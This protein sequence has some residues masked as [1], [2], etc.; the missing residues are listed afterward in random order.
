MEVLL[1]SARDS[2]TYSQIPRYPAIERDISL[3]VDEAVQAA[4]IT[5]LIRS[6]PGEYIEEVSVFDTF[7]GKNIPAGKKSLAFS[8]R[9]RSPE[10][11][12]TDEEVEKIHHSI[13][14][15][16]TEKTGGQVRA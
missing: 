8:I 14:E 2:V 10:R 15:H 12:L 3:V 13:V 16:V 11:T 5:A 1:S 4:D 9:Y 6:Y 7:T